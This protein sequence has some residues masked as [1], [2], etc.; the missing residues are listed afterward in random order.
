MKPEEINVTLDKYVKL[1]EDA[2]KKISLAEDPKVYRITS[3][4]Y[5]L[6]ILACFLLAKNIPEYRQVLGGAMLL[7]GVFLLSSSLRYNVK[8]RE[9][10][11]VKRPF[12]QMLF[13]I[14]EVNRFIFSIDS[15]EL[16]IKL[17]KKDN[18]ER[19]LNFNIE[20]LS[21]Y[22][23]LTGAFLVSNE[24]GID[25]IIPEGLFKQSNY[26][27]LCEAVKLKFDKTK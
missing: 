3:I 9:Q 15:N 19:D 18:T 23:W 21:A 16:K 1:L 2:Y 5:L 11:R 25:F 6:G 13:Q 4:V 27:Q 14:T 10:R 7:I 22:Q 12:D 24:D 17:E 20:K 8:K 26:Q